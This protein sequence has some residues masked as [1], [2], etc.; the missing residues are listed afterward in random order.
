VTS[1]SR[2][3]F[4]WKFHFYEVLLPLLRRLGPARFDA[5]VRAVGIAS[6]F[7]RPGRRARLQAAVAAADAALGLDSDGRS[8]FQWT[9]LAANA[10]RF[11]AR[12]YALDHPDDAEVLSRFE[13][14]GYDAFQRELAHGKG[15]ILVGSHL[16]AHIA[17]MHWLFRV[18]LPIRALVQRPKHV[19]MTLERRFDATDEPYPQRDFFLRRD[20]TPAVAVER[21]MQARSALR[22]GMIVYLN[23]DIA[24]EGSNTRACRL[25]GRDHKFLAIWTELAPLT[26]SPVFFVFCTHRPG[27]RFALEF[28]HFGQT[29]HGEQARALSAYLSQ[30]EAQIAAAPAEAVAYLTWPCYTDGTLTPEKPAEP[31]TL[32]PHRRLASAIA[33]RVGKGRDVAGSIMA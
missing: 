1:L 15:V 12:D 33:R 24:W 3:L 14:K 2:R 27:G 20:L 28:K 7:L 8:E 21:T 31:K 6:T 22:D 26:R 10:A 30:L 23:G 32:G 13:V 4:T 5:V 29:R 16:G 19:S 11:T 25:L 17:G 18:G 9:G